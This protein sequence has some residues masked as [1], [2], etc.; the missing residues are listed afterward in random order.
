[1]RDGVLARAYL[2]AVLPSTLLIEA[3]AG[4]LDLGKWLLMTRLL[5]LATDAQP[6]LIETLSI[7]PMGLAGLIGGVMLGG[8]S[9]E[10][11]SF[12]LARPHGRLAGALL[13]ACVLCLSIVGVG[14]GIEALVLL[15]GE[16]PRYPFLLGFPVVL[17]AI[18]CGVL[19]SSL[20]PHRSSAFGLSFVLLILGVVGPML[21]LDIALTTLQP[22]IPQGAIDRAWQ[23][24]SPWS[25]LALSGG[26]LWSWVHYQ[27]RWWPLVSRRAAHQVTL[28]MGA[29]HL[30]VAFLVVLYAL[31]LE[32]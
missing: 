17:Y 23:D 3:G 9:L 32:K 21:V 2:Q 10:G 28:R 16:I 12:F 26:A 25:L 18:L 31:G 30:L 29:T 15:L 6:P 27:R 11:R 1:M 19:V 13:A 8:E 5:S 14:V 4:L 24:L 20:M 22:A 7:L